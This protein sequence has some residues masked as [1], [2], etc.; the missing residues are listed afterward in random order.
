MPPQLLVAST[1]P[2]KLKELQDLL[3]GLPYQITGLATAT[4]DLK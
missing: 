4:A 1:N 3:A 2:K